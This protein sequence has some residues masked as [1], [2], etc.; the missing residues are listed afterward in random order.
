[1]KNNYKLIYIC[2]IICDICCVAFDLFYGSR[3]ML[4]KK[5]MEILRYSE[6]KSYA[7]SISD[8]QD[9]VDRLEWCN[10][11]ST[12]LEN[13]YEEIKSKC[14]VRI[15]LE[16]ADLEMNKSAYIEKLFSISK[17]EPQI[18]NDWMQII[19]KEENDQPIGILVQNQMSDIGIDGVK[20]GMSAKE[21]MDIFPNA[22]EESILYDGETV[23]YILLE[24]E[25]YRYY[26]VK[27][28]GFGE[29]TKLYIEKR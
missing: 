6:D 22:T 29:T 5:E 28:G 23:K 3:I 11:K 7:D 1:M 8:L 14:D 25:D 9:A 13:E 15:Y 24:D 27:A 21:I 10:L 16:S 19:Y 4:Q 20:L 18:K 12:E 2:F 26:Y 17:N